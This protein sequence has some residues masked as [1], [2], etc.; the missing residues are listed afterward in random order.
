MPNDMTDDE[1]RALIDARMAGAGNY[2][3]GPV[4]HR[5][6]LLSLAKPGDTVSLHPIDYGGPPTLY[7]FQED[8]SLLLLGGPSRN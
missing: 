3:S 1:L 4:S 7:E 5:D 6:K 2:L 8:G